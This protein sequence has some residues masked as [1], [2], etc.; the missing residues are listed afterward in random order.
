MIYDTLRKLPKIIQVEII[1]TGDL[2][3][4]TDQETPLELLIDLWDKLM[5]EFNKRYNAQEHNKTF[6][7]FKEIE[8]LEKKYSVI[9][10][11]IDALAFDI[12]QDLINML[13]EYGYRLKIENYNND[14]DRIN[15]ECEGITN[16]I[17]QFKNMLP[18]NG[19]EKSEAT[20]IDVMAS[21]T[22]IL[23]YDFD[24]YTI[25]VEK[26]HSL[27]KQVIQKIKNIEKQI[28]KNKK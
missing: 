6:N 17:N 27:E 24:F 3:L 1:E 26:F 8:F 9:K 19:N 16:K 12:N 5:E 22:I 25:S 10:A 13:L 2:T 20:I 4:L 11:A 28:T 21:Y 15:R 7:V 18:K 23:G 14:L